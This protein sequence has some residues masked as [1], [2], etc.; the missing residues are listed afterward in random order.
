[1]GALGNRKAAIEKDKAALKVYPYFLRALVFMG[2][3]LGG[4]GDVARA[5]EV[6]AFAVQ[7]YPQDASAQF[8]LALTLGKQPANQ[9]EAF[10]RAIELDPEIIAAHESLG[11]ALASDGQRPNAIKIFRQGLTIDPLSAILYYDLGVA[12]KQQG[13]EAAAKQ[14][15]TLAGRLDPDIAAHVARSQ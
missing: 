9:I 14:A 7:S 12:L 13:D 10:R 3:S 6:L 1:M 4:A 15:L 2:T 8:D 5:S 11:A